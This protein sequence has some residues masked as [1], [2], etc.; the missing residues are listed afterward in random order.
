M[1]NV[2]F[3]NHKE[4]QKVVHGFAQELYQENPEGAADAAGAEANADASTDSSD[5]SDKKDDDNV[6]DAEYEEVK[7][8]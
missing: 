7:E 3:W 5:A 1:K 8:K 6:V 2:L 4:L